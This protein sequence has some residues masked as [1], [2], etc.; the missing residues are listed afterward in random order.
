MQLTTLVLALAGLLTF[1]V[2]SVSVNSFG[3]EL[4]GPALKYP[5]PYPLDVFRFNGTLGGHDVQLNGTV[6][7]IMAQMKV[8]HPEFDP[9]TILNDPHTPLSERAAD[10]K[11]SLI[12]IKQ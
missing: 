11:A 4:A 10:N 6:Q 2:A 7:E 9:E 3:V 5:L 12:P 8:L 1:A